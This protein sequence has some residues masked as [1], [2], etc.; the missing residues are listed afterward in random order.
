M[1]SRI[2]LTEV[3]KERLVLILGRGCFR[4]MSFWHIAMCVGGISIRF[5][6]DIVSKVAK[7]IEPNL[8]GKHFTVYISTWMMFSIFLETA[9]F[10]I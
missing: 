9:P 7:R 1:V 2:M 5:F 4:C 10:K 8:S 3:R 6:V